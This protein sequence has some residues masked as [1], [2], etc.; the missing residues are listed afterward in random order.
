[1]YTAWD[2]DD[3]DHWAILPFEPPTLEEKADGK[4]AGKSSHQ[5]FLEESSFDAEACDSRVQS[6]RGIDTERGWSFQLQK[7][8][9]TNCTQRNEVE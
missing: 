5:P 9:R 7:I 1:M 8:E 4:S 2:T 6:L 3:I